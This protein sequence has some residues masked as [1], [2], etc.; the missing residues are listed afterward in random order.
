LRP[1]L[2]ATSPHV[3]HRRRIGPPLI[4]ALTKVGKLQAP[5]RSRSRRHRH[6]R[7]WRDAATRS[8]LPTS[9]PPGAN[10]QST[11]GR[12][13]GARRQAA[14]APPARPGTP[15]T[16]DDAVGLDALRRSRL[17]R[18]GSTAGL[19]QIVHRGR[20][21]RSL[22]GARS[23]SESDSGAANHEALLV[24]ANVARP[25]YQSEVPQ[26]LG[27]DPSARRPRWAWTE[28]VRTTP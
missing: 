27:L 12:A 21:R 1:L 11:A 16:V 7:S 23:D 6:C 2:L 4:G 18:S 10:E 13:D 24:S 25:G 9:L 3:A 8:A 19:P 20:D 17:G 14:S 22:A 26:F 5:K 28:R 15:A